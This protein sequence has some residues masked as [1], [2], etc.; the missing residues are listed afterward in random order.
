MHV[1]S[2][3]AAVGLTLAATAISAAQNS[4]APQLSVTT[5]IISAGG[6]AGG[7]S[8]SSVRAFSQM[9]GGD[10]LQAQIASLRDKDGS[11]NVD[12]FVRVLDYAFIDGWKRAGEANV[13]MP[14]PSSDTGTPL[15]LDTIRAGTR[16]DGTFEFARMMD[17]LWTPR[18]HA[19]IHDDIASTYGNNALANFER[20]GNDF[21]N[22]LAQSLHQP[23]A[24]P[25]LPKSEP[26][27]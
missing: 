9:I 18:V 4:P 12:S 22:G 25:S 2:I 27:A 19:R 15:A 17:A 26:A 23:T 24:S 8:F 20:L 21:F 3:L 5:A 13:K 10:A 6:G 14:P 11:G 1:R 7:G 16:S